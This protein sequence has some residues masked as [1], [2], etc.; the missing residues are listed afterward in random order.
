LALKP[1]IKRANAG[2]G[3]I[4]ADRGELE[5]AEKYYK[6]EINS[7]SKYIEDFSGLGTVLMNLKNDSDAILYFEKALLIDSTDHDIN[8]NLS[9]LYFNHQNYGAAKKIWERMLV[10]FPTQLQVRQSL[11]ILYYR[12]GDYE[13][14]LY[15]AAKEE[16]L[17][18]K[19]PEGFIKTMKELL[20]TQ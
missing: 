16:E 20:N 15:Y 9:F 6:A 11:A 12:I 10:L 5:K 4:Y 1:D 2:L 7:G 3:A 19:M 13:K 8:S 18:G 14:A 17:G